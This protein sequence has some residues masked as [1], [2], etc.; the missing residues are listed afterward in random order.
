MKLDKT[1]INSTAE[2]KARRKKILSCSYCPP[3]KDE[4]QKKGSKARAKGWKDKTKSKKQ[5]KRIKVF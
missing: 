2:W 5:F 4:N 1:E 3:N